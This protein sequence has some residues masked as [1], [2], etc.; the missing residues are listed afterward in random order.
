MTSPPTKE[1]LILVHSFPTNSILLNGL[2]EYMNQFFIVHF[3]DLPG[4]VKELG[5]LPENSFE[6]YAAFVDA[7]IARLKIP[8]YYI[9]GVSFGFFIINKAKLDKRC[10]GILAIEPY[11]NRDSLKYGK[12]AKVFIITSIK[13]IRFTRMEKILWRPW[14]MEK[15]INVFFDYP[16]ERIETVVKEIHPKTFFETAE[17]IMTEKRIVAFHKK[18]TVLFINSQ[19]RTVRADFTRKIFEKTAARLL[20]IDTTVEH[21]PKELSKEY[22]DSHI[23][24]NT[25]P[26]VLTFLKKYRT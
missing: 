23:P 6:A 20:V 10:K 22:F 16:R 13:I 8:S 9:G 26:R 15:T 11:I 7:Y 17:K 18:P 5:P 21:F 24:T 12:L 19:D 2:T 3:I 4:F 25:I 1:H 14:L